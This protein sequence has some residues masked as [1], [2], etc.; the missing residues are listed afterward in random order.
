ML[1]FA[2]DCCGDGRGR[3]DDLLNGIEDVNKESRVGR[4]AKIK[5]VSHDA[6]GSMEVMLT[7]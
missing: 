7:H 1:E 2:G 6:S 3:E 4:S 5:S